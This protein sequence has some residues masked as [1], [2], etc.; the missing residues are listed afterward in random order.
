[1]VGGTEETTTGVIRLQSMEQEGVLGYPIIAV[2]DADTKHLFDNRYGTGQSTLDGIVRATTCCWRAPLRGVRLRLGGP[3]RGVARA[4]AGARVIVTEIDP[5]H[6]LEAVMDGY[7][8]MTMAEAAKVGQ[9]FVT[10][11]GNKG[12]IR[13]EHFKEMRDGAIV[14]N[15]GHFN[16]ELDIPGLASL[17]KSKREVKPF[18]DEYVMKSG[19]RRIYLLGEGRLINLASAEG[20]PPP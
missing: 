15:S 13:K 9:I 14:C 3:R 1:V 4:R 11:T 17:S 19:G 10:V 2:N 16:V 6:A 20:I 18:V 8:V 5:T 12:I 7:E